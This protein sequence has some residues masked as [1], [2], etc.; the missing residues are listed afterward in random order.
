MAARF[1]VEVLPQ[2]VGAVVALDREQSRHAARV[3][4]L[5]AGAA[6]ELFDGSGRLA[7]AVV[8]PGEAAGTR[9]RVT[10]LHAAAPPAASRHLTLAT[11]VPKG[12]RLEAMVAQLVQLGCDR[13]VPLQTARG[14]VE[15]GAGKLERARR[16]AAEAMKQCGRLT[17]MEV[18]APASL[19]ALLAASADVGL[20]LLDPRGDA[21]PPGEA[22]AANGCLALVG[23]E[24]GWTED[25][26]RQ[27]VAAGARRWR[28]NANVL[29]IETAAVAAAAV[30][31]AGRLML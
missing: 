14:V 2:D 10:A 27:I 31:R 18:A 7:E 3:L 9:C 29:R 23:P 8:E 21:A 19:D 24:G 12:P 13:W 6:V 5:A 30:L 11:A 26:L 16:V 20:L 15:P 4:R 1:R 17:P 22:P 25:E 28:L